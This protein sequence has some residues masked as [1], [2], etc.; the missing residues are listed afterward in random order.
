MIRNLVLT[1]LTSGLLLTGALPAQ[2][3]ALSGSKSW[4]YCLTCGF[5]LRPSTG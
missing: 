5:R 2:A 4:P 1:A 3:A